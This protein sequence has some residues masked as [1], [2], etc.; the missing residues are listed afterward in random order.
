M[1]G[2]SFSWQMIVQLQTMVAALFLVIFLGVAH[3]MRFCLF[4]KEQ[5]PMDLLGQC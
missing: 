1:V 3:L 4:S 5:I 2:D